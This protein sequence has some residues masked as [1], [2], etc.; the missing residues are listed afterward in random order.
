MI[1]P[2]SEQ[3]EDER[4]SIIGWLF[5]VLLVGFT[6]RFI[7]LDS[8]SIW[9][10]EN[11]LMRDVQR[12]MTSFSDIFGNPRPLYYLLVLPVFELFGVS[13]AYARAVSAIIGA[14]SLPIF[15]YFVRQAINGRTALIGTLLLALSPWHL[16][17]SQ[18]ARFYTLLLLFFCL[19]YVFYYLALEKGYFLYTILAVGFLGAAVLSHSIGAVL[20]PLF[21][22]HYIV[23]K[24]APGSKPSGLRLITVLP[25]L[26]LPIVGYIAYEL[27]RVFVLDTNLFIVDFYNKF[28]SSD[29]A[30]FIGYSNQPLVMLTSVLY[31]VGYPLGILAAY[32]AFDL[33]FAQRKRLGIFLVL[34][35]FGPL[36]IMMFLTLFVESTTNRYVFMSLPFWMVLA[37][38]GVRRVIALENNVI[39]VLLLV[40]IGLSFVI[41][42]L[43]A[44]LF[45]Y[46]VRS[47]LLRVSLLSVVL[48][49]F[50][51][52]LYSSAEIKRSA[53]G[54]LLL[55]ILCIHPLIA[56]VLY[57]TSQHGHRDNWQGAVATI[58]QQAGP[59]D[60]VVTHPFPVGRYYL[61]PEVAWIEALEEQPERFEG[62]TVWLIEEFGI[63]LYFGDTMTQ[64]MKESN[65]QEVGDWSNYVA[66]NRWVMKLHKCSP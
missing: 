35:A 31:N 34:G 32:G 40:L 53:V 6:I 17:W 52:M 10:E 9:I 14:V 36:L 24:I 47:A 16:F 62:K 63:Q 57:F 42:P 58:R 28:V 26:V 49:F 60:E 38:S 48:A 54:Y 30:S 51:Y 4:Q 19:S 50:V 46:S 18:N 20:V 21:F 25:Y 8:W 37:A 61:G 43:I 64:W 15:Y 56:S 5:L 2:Y 12:Y 59:D 39:G 29:T 33:T 13:L 65:C 44:D 55:F 66:G 11:H 1:T 27:L 45:Y 7:Q 41:D 22:V 23:L 3:N